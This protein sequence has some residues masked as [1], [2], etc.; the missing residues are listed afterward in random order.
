MTTWIDPAYGVVP[1]KWGPAEVRRYALAVGAPA[2][3][4]DSADLRL[5]TTEQPEVLPTLAMLLADA[6]SLRYVPLPGLDYSPADVIYAGHELELLRPL[7]HEE[8]GTSTSRLLSV[9]DIRTG[10]LVRRE[11]VSV[12]RRGVPLARNIVTSVIRGARCGQPHVPADPEAPAAIEIGDT[13][14]DVQT[15]PQQALLYAQTGDDNPLHWDPAIAR[16]AGFERPILH[17]LCTAAIVARSVLDVMTDH[18]WSS[19]RRLSVRF[20][21]PVLPGDTLQVRIGGS[22]DHLSF[23]AQ[24]GE[25]LVLSDGVL[26]LGW[27]S[28]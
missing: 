10:V 3:P 8:S 1:W 26:D 5:V 15:L 4:V 13:R 21:S 23:N 7:A 25:R 12:D 17:G 18:A 20:R 22:G 2:S 24:V 6:H 19:L 9:G 16:A 14:I 28:R 27:E 11:T